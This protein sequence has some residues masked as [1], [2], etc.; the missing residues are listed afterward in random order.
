VE[1]TVSVALLV[2]RFVLDPLTTFNNSHRA[3]V[4]LYWAA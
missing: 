4:L 2:P 3:F 1:P